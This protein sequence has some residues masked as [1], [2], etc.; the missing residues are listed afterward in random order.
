[1]KAYD[2]VIHE[3][4]AQ[5]GRIVVIAR[6]C[7]CQTTTGNTFQACQIHA[8]ISAEIGPAFLQRAAE[9]QQRYDNFRVPLIHSS[10]VPENIEPLRRL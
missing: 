10:G 6:D 9:E 8:A 7:A 4:P 1:M 3:S 5:P 2:W